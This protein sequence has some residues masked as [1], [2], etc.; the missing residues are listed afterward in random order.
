MN[1][2]RTKNFVAVFLTQELLAGR[3]ALHHQAVEHNMAAFSELSLSVRW[4]GMLNRAYPARTKL[5]V[6]TTDCLPRL[7][8]NWRDSDYEKFAL[9]LKTK[10]IRQPKRKLLSSSTNHNIL[11]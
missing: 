3:H 9:V 1:T 7:Q 10:C 4:Q 2:I 11:Y 6:L 5:V 8:T